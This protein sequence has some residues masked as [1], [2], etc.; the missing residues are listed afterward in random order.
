MALADLGEGLGR[1]VNALLRIVP[2][3]QQH[4]RPADRIAVD[5]QA[6]REARIDWQWK[7]RRRDVTARGAIDGLPLVGAADDVADVAA[8]D[9][10]LVSLLDRAAISPR[11]K[12]RRAQHDRGEPAGVRVWGPTG[13]AGRL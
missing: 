10:E 6:S 12:A 1:E 4:I 13:L 9:Q 7:P 3:P 8:V 5:R 11:H 2:V